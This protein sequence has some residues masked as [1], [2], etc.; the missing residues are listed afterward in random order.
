MRKTTRK[1]TDQPPIAVLE[2]PQRSRRRTCYM[3]FAIGCL[4]LGLV[5]LFIVTAYA[6]DDETQIVNF[7]MDANLPRSNFLSYIGRSLGW[8]I[9][10]GLAYLV[11]G[12]SYACQKIGQVIDVSNIIKKLGLQSNLTTI[13]FVLLT[14]V[15][16]MAAL[17]IMAHRAE[18]KNVAL[19]LIIG[20]CVFSIFAGSS[21]ILDNLYKLPDA[22]MGVITGVDDSGN[23]NTDLG[24]T[25]MAG[26]TV[27]VLQYDKTYPNLTGIQ[28]LADS[29][30]A[31]Q[32]K[33]LIETL[34]PTET[35][36]PDDS[37]YN[38]QNKDVFGKRVIIRDGKLTLSDKLWNGTIPLINLHIPFLSEQ[39]YRWKID[40]FPMIVS[41]LALAFALLFTAIKIARILF[42]LIVK[43]FLVQVLSL[44]DMVSGQK[45]KQALQSFLAS[46]VTLFGCNFMLLLYT[47]CNSLIMRTINENFPGVDQAVLRG[48]LTVIIQIAL[49][50]AVID[51]PA[52]FEKLFGIDVGLNNPLRTLFAAQT[53]AHMAGGVKRGIMGTV[54]AD[55]HRHGGIVGTAGSI[56]RFIA[57]GAS[58]NKGNSGQKKG[59]RAGQT[60]SSSAG[61]AA[62]P[63]SSA[64]GG[65][66]FSARPGP[67]GG[68]TSGSSTTAPASSGG[69]AASNTQ[70]S[71]TGSN[72]RSA[73]TATATQAA[74]SGSASSNA[75]PGPT[76]NNAPGAGAAVPA[77]TSSSSTS[78]ARPGPTGD[79]GATAAAQAA[80]IGSAAAN[81]VQRGS[82]GSS[83]PGA[84]AA[85]QTVGNN[86]AL[87]NT[88]PG[89]TGSTGSAT[90]TS[91]S[92]VQTGSNTPN[93]R[94]GPTE[95]IISGANPNT[96]QDAR[97]GPLGSNMSGT[98]TAVQSAGNGNVTSNA[99]PGPSGS[100][101]SGRGAAQSL[102]NRNATTNIR[103]GNTDNNA[104]GLNANG[105]ITS[106]NRP[107]PGDGI[108]SIS[109]DMAAGNGLQPEHRPGQ[110]TKSPNTSGTQ[111]AFSSNTRNT[112]NQNALH[113]APSGA[114]SAFSTAPDSSSNVGNVTRPSHGPASPA[115]APTVPSV[116][117]APGALP[118]SPAVPPMNGINPGAA[119]PYATSPGV[120]P[121][122]SGVIPT[123]P[124]ISGGQTVVA[125]GAPSGAAPVASTIRPTA[126]P[127][128]TPSGARPYSTPSGAV[129]VSSGVLP[130][131]PDISGGQTV[132]TT[133]APSGAAPVTST[134]RPTARPYSP[135]SGA[136][137]VSSDISTGGQT[138]NSG[139][140][141]GSISPSNSVGTKKYSGSSNINSTDPAH[142]VTP[143]SGARP[144]VKEQSPHPDKK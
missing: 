57:S 7:L 43:Q 105:N 2:T 83:T 1:P 76:A 132:M 91:T 70:P 31:D 107:G 87:P 142:S 55:G 98:G 93:T 5:S 52:I 53:A 33:Q 139:K 116:P 46:L 23:A 101:A 40:W 113:P 28:T 109:T 71:Q 81:N 135:P 103:P 17:L 19:N 10:K 123:V 125:T 133:S 50:W 27:D 138:A 54:G 60:A 126:R 4:I 131:A 141:S 13:T 32:Q 21:A 106:D 115:F 96:A 79:P 137:P 104:L 25:N 90:N 44:T 100:N 114:T 15:L 35:V 41:M 51:G 84:N 136:A 22:A 8:T 42:E 88:R 127:Y 30:S 129:P 49:A 108:G 24:T 85:T 11:N 121:V 72:G 144:A 62:L 47:R 58:K 117:G 38:I 75:R 67:T 37:S 3:L 29:S 110:N 97:P 66:G 18:L 73:S 143:P 134:I 82:G 63:A 64:G 118:V 45:L 6:A 68:N 111:N 80:A 128:S 26:Y 120:A 130:A 94:P 86:N 9:C 39:Y 36:D 112:G 74:G 14:L 92:S 89:P 140:T 69:S 56:R 99:R 102:G 20:L 12:I 95:G 124:D 48:F 78:S 34:D 16:L 59:G 122:F 119:R 65:A 77:P 61:G